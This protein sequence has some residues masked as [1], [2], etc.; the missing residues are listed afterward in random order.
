MPTPL[1]SA[2]P[3]FSPS[4][5]PSATFAISSCDVNPRNAVERTPFQVSFARGRATK[6]RHR[7]VENIS[8]YNAIYTFKG[9]SLGSDG[10][11][12]TTL[13]P[14]AIV[15]DSASASAPFPVTSFPVGHLNV[16]GVATDIGTGAS[17][18]FDPVSIRVSI[19]KS[20]T[21]EEALQRARQFIDVGALE[22]AAWYLDAFSVTPQFIP[23]AK[24]ILDVANLLTEIVKDLDNDDV[25]SVWNIIISTNANIGDAAVS[26]ANKDL[27]DDE[28]DTLVKAALE[29]I[30]DALDHIL[31]AEGDIPV[32][33]SV[34]SAI[35]ATL[36]NIGDAYNDED[37]DINDNVAELYSETVEAIKTV[38]LQEGFVN[39]ENNDDCEFKNVYESG[40]TV[41]IVSG[42]SDSEFEQPG[43]DS[44]FI[45]KDDT[46]DA[47]RDKNG[48]VYTTQAQI[49]NFITCSS[50]CCVGRASEV[51]SFTF[52]DPSDKFAPVDFKKKLSKSGKNKVYFSI[53]FNNAFSSRSAEYVTYTTETSCGS[54]TT[55]KEKVDLEP[56]CQFYEEKS[57]CFSDSGC[58][59]LKVHDNVVDCVCDHLTDYAVVFGDSDGGGGGGGG[60]GCSSTG[61]E[62]DWIMIASLVCF[63][64]AICV[65]LVIIVCFTFMHRFR[66]TVLGAEGDRIE[67]LHG[68]RKLVRRGSASKEQISSQPSPRNVHNARVP[69]SKR[70]RALT[71]SMGPEAL[72]TVRSENIEATT[73]VDFV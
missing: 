30:I 17:T 19:D 72:A 28:V 37:G 35:V 48:C 6:R 60:G 52:Y 44:G 61:F 69:E 10:L 59:T 73:E 36:D 57:G 31:E 13:T 33:D 66:K 68:N 46:I 40:S 24:C 32:P 8:L 12:N 50:K 18:I 38:A 43:E 26:N 55:K 56:Q 70:E 9:S 3:Y 65:V 29:N 27:D 71:R 16:W 64:V 41:I 11:P 5:A 22:E 14:W 42:S 63:G 25:S 54:S 47:L 34:I 62:W 20:T 39:N 23:D 53:P 7:A 15:L 21:C 45:F 51:N 58:K 2:I 67:R 4:P 49:Q 1:P